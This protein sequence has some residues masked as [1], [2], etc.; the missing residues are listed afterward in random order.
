MPDTPDRPKLPAWFD[1]RAYTLP[2]S[3]GAWMCPPRPPLICAT[4]DGTHTLI[5]I[6]PAAHRLATAIAQAKAQLIAETQE[7]VT[8]AEALE[9][10]QDACGREEDE[11]GPYC[12]QEGGAW[13]AEHCPFNDLPPSENGPIAWG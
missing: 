4:E 2:P 13:C 1:T 11:D 5:P 3:E 6:S 12:P 9:H 8:D 10:L 7:T